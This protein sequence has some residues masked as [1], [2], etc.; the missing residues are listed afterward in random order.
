M[1]SV[2]E[3]KAVGAT[4]TTG[5]RPKAP[6]IPPEVLELVRRAS[7]GEDVAVP[8]LRLA[9][10]DHPELTAELGDL[11]ALAEGG[12]IQLAAGPSLVSREAIA[13]HVAALRADLGEAG[14]SP[15]ERLLIRRV[16]LSWLS[17]HVGEIAR[18]EK[19]LA[20]VAEPSLAAA[21]KRV[22]RA[23]ARFV[24][25]ARALAT[26]R[27]LV[28]PGLSA[29]ELARAVIPEARPIAVNRVRERVAA[30]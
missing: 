7:G 2:D 4:P 25:A 12:L 3:P 15:L 23:H 30:N 16:A 9:L 20:R 26:V 1:V 18:V 21:E 19:R 24:S 14:A 8:D 22:D 5:P 10:E 29:V 27:K 13:A 28:R 6:A 11:A 17:L